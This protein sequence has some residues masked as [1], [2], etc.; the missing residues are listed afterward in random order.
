MV[1]TMRVLRLRTHD[2]APNLHEIIVPL[3][4][5]SVIFEIWLPGTE[6]F[7]GLATA[8]HRDI[9]CYT[10]GALIA[11]VVWHTLYERGSQIQ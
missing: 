8:D 11:G 1:W 4:L 9:L 7:H 2:S 10:L 3:L 6:L 5:W